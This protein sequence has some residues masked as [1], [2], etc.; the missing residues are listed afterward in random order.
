MVQH[1]HCTE[2]NRP[3][4]LFQV[5]SSQSNVVQHLEPSP[6]VTYTQ[7]HK[8]SGFNKIFRNHN[9]SQIDLIMKYYRIQNSW[10]FQG[11][12]FK[13]NYLMKQKSSLSLVNYYTWNDCNT[14]TAIQEAWY[15]CL[16]RSCHSRWAEQSTSAQDAVHCDRVL[17]DKIQS[18]LNYIY[19]YIYTYPLYLIYIY[20]FF[21]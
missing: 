19:I 20:I 15:N 2:C 7:S 13:K 11:E 1:R 18:K 3:L 12:E 6:K 16:Q 5:L 8:L 21:Y 10:L 14:H 17:P 4:S 9:I